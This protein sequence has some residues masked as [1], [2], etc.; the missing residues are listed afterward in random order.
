MK[1]RKISFGNNLALKNKYNLDFYVCT[2]ES[3]YLP[4]SYFYG[5]NGHSFSCGKF[6]RRRMLKYK[7][8]FSRILNQKKRR[9]KVK[10][11]KK[12]VKNPTIFPKDTELQLEYPSQ[13]TTIVVYF[14]QQMGAPH[15]IHWSKSIFWR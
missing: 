10:K 2:G 12:L 6:V 1:Q 3:F 9:R 8:S 7:F 5:V 13:V 4:L 11:R 15:A 14:D